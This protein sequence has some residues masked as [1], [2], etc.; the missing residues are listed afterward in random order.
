MQYSTNLH[1]LTSD[2]PLITPITV[3]WQKEKCAL[4]GCPF[5]DATDQH[6]TIAGQKLQ[7]Y[8]PWLCDSIVPD[9]NC[10]FRCLSKIICGTEK[11]HNKI[12]GEV[13]RYMLYDGKDT[14]SWYF[15][16]VLSTTPVMHI[17]NSCMYQNG[18][19][20]TDAELIAASAILQSDI[21]VA[22]RTYTT[23]D[24]TPPDILWSRIRASNNNNNNNNNNYAL[25][26]RN[27]FDHYEPVTKM[28]NSIK[29]TFFMQDPNV[30]TIE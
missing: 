18:I 5:E 2:D 26:I 21:Y 17:S 28:I 22:N 11:Y 4:L 6:S 13:C 7:R 27:Y 8:E 3:E 25:Y 23:S 1:S 12:R 10:L 15:S 29:P 9:G 14:L 20:G 19:W 30:I 16:Q 24:T